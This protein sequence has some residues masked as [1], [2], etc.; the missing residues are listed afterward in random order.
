MP[1]IT[2][3]VAS[4]LVSPDYF[5]ALDI[6]MMQGAGFREEDMNA[7]QRSIVLSKRLADLFFPNDKSYWATNAVWE[8][9]SV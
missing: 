8:G 3:V 2:G 6:S 7:S 1:P 4:R 9:R 5:R